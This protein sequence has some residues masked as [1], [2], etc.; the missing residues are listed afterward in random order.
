MELILKKLNLLQKTFPNVIK[1]IRGQGLLVGIVLRKDQ[2]NFIKMLMDH[3]LLTVRASENV[4][5]LL[6]PLNV[7]KRE[8]DLA[9]K[10]IEKVCKKLQMKKIL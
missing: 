3:K 10:I 2:T 5:R 7:R 8:L 6:P 1:E 9:L 4:V